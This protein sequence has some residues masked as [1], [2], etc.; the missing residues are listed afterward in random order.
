MNHPGLQGC[1]PKSSSIK[2]ELLKCDKVRQRGIFKC[3]SKAFDCLFIYLFIYLFIFTIAQREESVAFVRKQIM[4]NH[5][6]TLP[7]Q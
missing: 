1:Q 5:N 7:H 6:Q 2:P 3:T 4:W